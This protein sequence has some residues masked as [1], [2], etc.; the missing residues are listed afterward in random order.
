MLKKF[1]IAVLLITSVVVA[2]LTTGTRSCV[3][4]ITDD[5]YTSEEVQ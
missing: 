4:I 5:T 3:K 1:W 2:Q